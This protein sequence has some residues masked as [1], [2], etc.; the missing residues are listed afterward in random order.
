MTTIALIT[1]FA[2][3][4]LALFSATR[5]SIDSFL[6]LCLA[7]SLTVPYE[8]FAIGFSGEMLSK[9]SPY[10]VFIGTY[11]VAQ[12]LI[13]SGL[14]RRQF[15]FP[16]TAAPFAGI[17]LYLSVLTYVR[18]GSSGFGTIIDNHLSV[19]FLVYILA[20][21]QNKIILAPEKITLIALVVAMYAVIESSIAYN[22]IYQHLFSQASWVDTQWS[23]SL[24]RSTATIGHPLIA[25]T[26][27]LIFISSLNP[28]A[29][30]KNLIIV[31]ILLL[32]VASTG[33]RAAIGLSIVSLLTQI[34]A[35]HRVSRSF[36][37]AII[38]SSLSVLFILTGYFD[39]LIDRFSNASGSDAVR[40]ALFDIA[41]TAVRENLFFGQGI[42]SIGEYTYRIGFFNVL[43]MAWL[44]LAIEMGSMGLIFYIASWATLIVQQGLWRDNKTTVALLF[45][46]LGTFNSIA[47]HTPIIVVF[48]IVIFCKAQSNSATP[49]PSR[50][51]KE[52]PKAI[53]APRLRWH[54]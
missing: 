13:K 1:L 54:P 30:L 29:N 34:L 8:I 14:H 33:S 21:Y 16:K 4:A 52:T 43:E 35:H 40:L 38:V 47:V 20:S 28:A 25:A 2:C 18:Q 10:S 50:S 46:M 41:G 37:S 6:I 7:I 19:F 15:I 24:H 23:S 36:F 27:F 3:I 51:I 45:V 48:L 53:I 11:F 5:R 12:V 22:L 32:A 42:G 26:V 49:K 44:T 9:I 39:Q 17:L 31:F